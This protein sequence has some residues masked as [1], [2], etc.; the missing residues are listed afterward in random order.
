MEKID[1]FEEE[2]NCLRKKIEEFTNLPV[3]KFKQNIENGEKISFDDK[4]WEEKVHPGC[5]W[6]LKDGP[7]Y[8]RKWIEIPS[9]IEGIKLAG[10]NIDLLFLFPSG[11]EVFIDE[12]KVYEC[13]FWADQIVIPFPFIQNA[14]PYEK[15]LVVFKTPGGDG[16]GGFG[17]GL[18]VDRVEEILFEIKTIFYQI[19]FALEI[20]KWKRMKNFEKLIEEVVNI[21]SLQDLKERKWEDFLSQVKEAEKLLEKLR[22][23]AKKFK[24]HLIGHAHIDMNWLW[25]YSDTINTCIRDFSTVTDLMAQNSDL[26]F[27]QSQAHV[28]KIVEENKPQI[29]EKVKERIK[30]GRWDVTANAWVEGDLN[31]VEGES[32]VRHILYT[33]KYTEEKLGTISCVMWCPDTFG[34]PISIPTILKDAN[35]KYY[36]FMRCGKNF[37]LFIWKGRNGAEVIAFNSV[38]NNRIEPDRF[39]PQ[40]IDFYNR[41]HLNETMFVYGIGDHGGGPTKIDIE[42]K[43][44]LEQKPVIPSLEFSTTKKFFSYIEKFRSKL[45]IIKEELNPAFEGCYTTHSDIKRINRKCEHLLFSFETINAITSIEGDVYLNKELEEMWQVVLFNQFHDILDGSAIHSSYEYSGLIAKQVEE[46]T[47]KL[48]K[49]RMEFLCSSKDDENVLIFNPT[50]WERDGIVEFEIPEKFKNEKIYLEGENE[51]IF[52]EVNNSNGVC[53]VE[54]VPGYGYKS[55]IIRKGEIKKIKC[56]TKKEEGIWETPF[57]LIEIDE[58]MGLIKRIYD[59]KN[60]REV[61]TPCKGIN[62]DR[63]SFWAETSGNL[64]K[65]LWE[66]P[67]PMSAWIIGNIYKIENLF[68]AEEIKIEETSLKTII[69]IKRKY[70]NSDIYQKIILYSDFPYIDFE[71]ELD[72]KEQGNKNVGVPMVRV[73]FNFNI[74]NIKPLFEIPFGVYE[75]ENKTRE[76]SAL[77]WAGFKENDYLVGI[78]NKEKYGYYIDGKNLSLTILRNPYEPDSSPDFGYQKIHYR[79]YFGEIDEVEISR[80]AEEFN[81]PF[82]VGIGK[83]KYKKFSL[84]KIDGNVMITIFKKEI[85][86]NGYILR[87][88]EIIGEKQKV[89]ISF[90]KKPISIFFSNL[91]EEKIKEIKIKKSTL[92]LE[93]APYSIMTLNIKY[94][95]KK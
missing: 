21:L 14:I 48:I 78:I 90:L 7:A 40:F 94:K 51:K 79:I 5:T 82:L 25:T 27:S 87:L 93:I 60:E 22:P 45:P 4:E 36:Y 50:G 72:W 54:K 29:F 85:K 63:S 53:K 66:T 8:F 81:K 71:L 86:G 3:W 88:N 70:Q 19:K 59:K 42:R 37:P 55:F 41:Y 28:Y 38:Y 13:K 68:A 69:K 10:S 83:G 91:L 75:R 44:I 35:I 39:L 20:V 31:M 49:E 26:T 15:H 17:V 33:R 6:S 56:I 80:K 62:E 57:Y 77:K 32:I 61:I 30:E 47:E 2:I 1:L 89:K 16:L 73:N 95:E 11:V 74:E 12:K 24:L 9:E 92:Q 18:W 34:H 76:Y 64:L 58:K 43:K 65:I 52:V 67:H 84:F 23:I 46:K